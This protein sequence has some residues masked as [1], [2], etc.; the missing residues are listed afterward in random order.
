MFKFVIVFAAC[1]A[2]ASAGVLAPTALA[3]APA[4]GYANAPLYAAGGSSQVDV[5]HNYDGTLSSY[6]T[7]PFAYSGPYSS[8]YVAGPAAY[9]APTA[10][11]TPAK[12]VAPATYAAAPAHFA[13]P[14]KVVAPYAAPY[15]TPFAAQYAAP[16]AAPFAAPYTTYGAAPV[17]AT[18][19]APAPVVA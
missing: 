5:R 9:A 19:A 16:Y 17:A 11:A 4:I 6:T 13:A 3:A 1:L 7:T 14:A 15:A 12:V 18:Y 8:R 2:Y 10:F